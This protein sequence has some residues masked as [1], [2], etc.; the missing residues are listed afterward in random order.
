MLYYLKVL[1]RIKIEDF[2]GEMMEMLQ[3]DSKS[4]MEDFIENKYGIQLKNKHLL[5]L[6]L[7]NLIENYLQEFS[8]KD[9]ETDFLF[10]YLE[11]LYAY[12]QNS[13][14]TLKDFLRF[15]DEEGNAKTVSYTHLDV[16]KRQVRRSLTIW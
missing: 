3:L 9:K 5:Q 13:G 10:N 11:M 8:V 4:E 6:N 12:C 14:S 2:T 1:G 15:W 7:Y 16:Y